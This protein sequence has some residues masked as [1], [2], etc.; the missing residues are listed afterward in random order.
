MSTR[1]YKEYLNLRLGQKFRYT[2]VDPTDYFVII[3]NCPNPWNHVRYNV[4]RHYRNGNITKQTWDFSEP[5]YEI[6]LDVMYVED[7][8][9]TYA[10]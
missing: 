9:I 5:P 8:P 6:S 2:F 4:S 7:G 10:I 1:D 3:S